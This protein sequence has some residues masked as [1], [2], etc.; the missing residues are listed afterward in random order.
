MHKEKTLLKEMPDSIYLAGEICILVRIE[1]LLLLRNYPPLPH[2]I[3]ARRLSLFG[4]PR[5][6]LW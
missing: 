2:A 5:D 1:P 3:Q 4:K 6:G